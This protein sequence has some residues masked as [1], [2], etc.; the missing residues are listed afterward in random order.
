[1]GGQHVGLIETHDSFIFVFRGT[2]GQVSVCIQLQGGVKGEQAW[3]RS[4]DRGNPQHRLSYIRKSKS[5]LDLDLDLDLQ[6]DTLTDLLSQVYFGCSE[7]KSMEIFGGDRGP[8]IPA[9]V[10]NSFEE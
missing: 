3:R 6:V 1:M 7:K 4:I 8:I 5:D 9:S 10:F 2:K